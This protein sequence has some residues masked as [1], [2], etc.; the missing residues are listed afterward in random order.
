MAEWWFSA[1]DGW[2]VMGRYLHLIL[3]ETFESL[4]VL[5]RESGQNC[6]GETAILQM[7]VISELTCYVLS[8]MLLIHAS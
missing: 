3:A 2:V 8:G 5:G 4:A 7:D 6:F 1:D